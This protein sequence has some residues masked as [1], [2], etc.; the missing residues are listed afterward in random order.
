LC[1]Y[2]EASFVTP[3]WS[4]IEGVLVPKLLQYLTTY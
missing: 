2:D 1:C 3:P 4:Y